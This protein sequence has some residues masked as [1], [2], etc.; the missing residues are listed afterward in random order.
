MRNTLYAA[1]R[2]K[3]VG[4]LYLRTGALG[5]V[6]DDSAFRALSAL[7]GAFAFVRRRA[8]EMMRTLIVALAL[9]TAPAQR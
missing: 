4:V 6:I 1:E 5:L 7:A 2:I 9:V 3:R 8:R